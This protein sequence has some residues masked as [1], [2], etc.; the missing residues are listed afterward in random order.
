[1]GEGVDHR[2]GRDAGVADHAVRADAHAV[3]QH[4]LALEDA[5]DVDL[6]VLAALQ[7]AAHIESRRVGQAHAGSISARA[8]RRW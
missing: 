3:A 2:A 1:V 8:W 6:H 7:R 5:A 4:D